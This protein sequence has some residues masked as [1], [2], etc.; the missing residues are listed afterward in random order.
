MLFSCNYFS[1]GTQHG[2]CLDSFTAIFQFPVLLRDLLQALGLSCKLLTPA[3]SATCR[4][5]SHST[6]LAVGW[7]LQFLTVWYAVLV[8]S[9]GCC[10]LGHGRALCL[11]L[12]FMLSPP[13]RAVLRCGVV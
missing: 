3:T 1:V 7:W 2:V 8:C 10:G 12:L 6:A 11:V 4:A 9:P 13:A 5:D